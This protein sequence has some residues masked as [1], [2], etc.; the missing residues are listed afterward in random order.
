MGRQWAKQ[1]Y[2][3]IITDRSD[4]KIIKAAAVLFCNQ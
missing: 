2:L 3:L 1:L 4:K